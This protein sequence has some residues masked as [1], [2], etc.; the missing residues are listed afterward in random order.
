LLAT[1]TGRPLP[2]SVRARLM[3]SAADLAVMQDD[4][5]VARSLSEKA[6]RLGRELADPDLVAS[7][8]NTVGLVARQTGDLDRARAYLRECVA[9]QEARGAHDAA[10]AAARSNLAFI[11]IFDGD[12]DIAYELSLRN[13]ELNRAIGN[14]RVL[15]FSL[16]NL[17][18]CSLKRGDIAGARPLFTEAL[19]ISQRIADPI[20]EAYITRD[21]GRVAWL[22]GDPVG[23]YAWYAAAIRLG[24]GVGKRLAALSGLIDFI[25]LLS[26]VE[27]AQAARLLSAVETI[28]DRSSMPMTRHERAIR[29]ETMHRVG[30]ALT[31]PDL[32][33]ATAAGRAMSLDDVVAEAL[34]VDPTVW[35]SDRPP[36]TVPDDHP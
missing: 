19:E 7:A 2:D 24:H 14:F 25:E 35:A 33:A 16:A 11:E 6:L 13:V 26:T 27:P 32:A 30:T 10:L 22:E 17:G 29:D 15:A 5:P 18:L 12:A 1:T 8:L 31:A 23:A 3:Q 21:L 34:A 4:Y 28:R 9:I 36:T 20:C